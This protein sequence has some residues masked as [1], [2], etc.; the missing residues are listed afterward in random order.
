MIACWWPS[1]QARKHQFRGAP[2][3]SLLVDPVIIGA[4]ICVHKRSDKIQPRV[5]G[6]VRE[7]IIH[8]ALTLA[9]RK[10]DQQSQRLCPPQGFASR[11][12][13]ERGAEDLCSGAFGK[14][15][16]L[17]TVQNRIARLVHSEIGRL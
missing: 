7:Q 16:H 14:E 9:R 2:G 15:L 8:R 4:H 11:P 12:L 1:N 17:K 13:G 6:F 3:K 5:A 10:P